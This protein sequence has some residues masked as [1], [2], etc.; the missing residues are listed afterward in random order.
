MSGSIQKSVCIVAVLVLAI[1]ASAQDTSPATN[2]ATAPRAAG[3]GSGGRP[4]P[5]RTAASQAATRAVALCSGMWEG[6]RSVEQ[7]NADNGGL[8]GTEMMKT[9]IDASRKV[10]SITYSD[11]MPPRIVA[12][13]PILGC[14]QLPIGATAAAIP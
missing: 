1:P 6:G 10:V 8:G 13:R 14:A 2:V 7:V 11:V 9:E 12:W 4:T 5:R 3:M